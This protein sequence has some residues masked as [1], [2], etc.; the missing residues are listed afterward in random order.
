MPCS[1]DAAAG[2]L[3]GLT[4]LARVATAVWLASNR[5]SAGEWV[6]PTLNR[7]TE[8]VRMWPDWL[9]RGGLAADLA[10]KVAAGLSAAGLLALGWLALAAVAASTEMPTAAVAAAASA[11]CMGLTSSDRRKSMTKSAYYYYRTTTIDD[12]QPLRAAIGEL[13]YQVLL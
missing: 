8:P 4:V 5:S 13:R 12:W 11:R 7:D 9:T 1:V 2:R 3:A 6:A 10:A